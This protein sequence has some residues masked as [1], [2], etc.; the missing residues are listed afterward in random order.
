MRVKAACHYVELIVFNR[1]PPP[2][3]PHP[4]PP[5]IPA[6]RM[7]FAAVRVYKATA[8]DLGLPAKTSENL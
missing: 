6:L 3:P 5:T 7:S 1:T 2:L 8:V 4:L